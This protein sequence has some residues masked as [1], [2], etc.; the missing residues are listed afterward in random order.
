M[1]EPLPY[2]PVSGGEKSRQSPGRG[3]PGTFIQRPAAEVSAFAV[4]GWTFAVGERGLA[5]C[6]IFVLDRRNHAQRTRLD[7]HFGG[8]SVPL[9][10]ERNFRYAGLSRF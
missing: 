9:K 3:I 6:R 1:A 4:G 5:K 8:L 7:F 10:Y 2:R